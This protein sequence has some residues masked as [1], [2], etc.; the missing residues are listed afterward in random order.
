VIVLS[1]AKIEVA[2]SMGGQNDPD[3]L[4]AAGEAINRAIKTWNRRHAWEFLRID[5]ALDFTVSAITSS[6]T[7]DKTLT[8]SNVQGF[9]NVYVGTVVSGHASIVA[10][11]KVVSKNSTN[12]VIVVDTD[13]LAPIAG[14]ELTFSGPIPIRAGVQDYALPYRARKAMYARLVTTKKTLHYQHSRVVNRLV[15]P[16]NEKG[17]WGYIYQPI[18]AAPNSAGILPLP[19]T[20]LRLWNKPDDLFEDTLVHEVIRAI[21]PFLNDVSVADEARPLD[22]KEDYE[23]ALL[24]LAEFYYMDNKDSE[25]AR[26]G[27]RFQRA[28]LSL[29]KSIADDLGMPDHDM[30]FIPPGDA[31]STFR[32]RFEDRFD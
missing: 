6:G 1:D 20:M 16:F 2:R 7:G 19:V 11:T 4:R 32:G 9:A 24:E 10:G 13:L 29:R 22:V 15:D 8:T 17:V 27:N 31:F 30:A 14:V 23:D 25:V 3:E 12:T 28:D 21:Q 26:T 18:Q 5:N